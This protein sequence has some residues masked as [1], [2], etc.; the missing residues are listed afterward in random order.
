MDWLER[1][2]STDPTAALELLEVPMTTTNTPT[3]P[4]SA[5]AFVQNLET[6][7]PATADNGTYNISVNYQTPQQTP[8]GTN[9]EQ[10]LA[11]YYTSPTT[12]IIR[13]APGAS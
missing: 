5:S 10:L 7:I 4:Q 9:L 3:V 8:S 13:F 1:L 11:G 12:H 2:N 6:L